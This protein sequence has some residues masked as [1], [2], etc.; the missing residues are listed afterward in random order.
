MKK[1]IPKF[2]Q[3]AWDEKQ[4]KSADNYSKNENTT[5]KSFTYGG[6]INFIPTNTNLP[7][8]PGLVPYK[9]VAASGQKYGKSQ[10]QKMVEEF[11]R[12]SWTRQYQGDP[13]DEYLF[14]GGDSEDTMELPKGYFDQTGFD[15]ASTGASNPAKTNCDLGIHEYVNIG[16]HHDKFV[17]KHCDREQKEL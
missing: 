14:N 7:L 17:C 8:R 13:F 6:I 9:T 15:W 5:T 12:D 1:Q 11:S 3:K 10:Y 4:A 16:F 2:D